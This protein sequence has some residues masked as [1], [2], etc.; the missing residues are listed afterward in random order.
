M[1]LRVNKKVR[2]NHHKEDGYCIGY[3]VLEGNFSPYQIFDYNW[4]IL[5]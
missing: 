2:N 4:N 1:C 5:L 3:K